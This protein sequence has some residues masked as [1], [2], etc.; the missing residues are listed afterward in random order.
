MILIGFVGCIILGGYSTATSLLGIVPYN[1]ASNFTLA[2]M[3]IFIM[4]GFLIAESG[5]GADLY[6]AAKTWLGRL[7][8]GLAIATIGACGFFAAVCGDSVTSA[9]TMSNVSFPEMKK[10]GYGDGTA[11]AAVCAGGA[12]GILIPPSVC[13]IIYGLIT[14]E[15]IGK[16]FIAGIIP[17]VLLVLMYMGVIVIK[18]HGKSGAIPSVGDEKSTFKEKLVSLKLVWP[19]L[20][21][22]VVMMCGMYMGFFTPNEAASVGVVVTLIVAVAG[23]RLPWKKF[24]S[25]LMQ[26][27]TYSA[28]IYLMLIG[29][30]VFLRFMALSRLPAWLSENVTLLYTVYEI[31]RVLILIII[32]I[33]YIIFGMFMDVFAT[34]LLTLGF[35]YPVIEILGYDLIWFG[36]IMT[37][38][39]EV[40]LISPPFGLNLFVVSKSC[41]VPMN[42]LYRGIMPF[43]GM[44]FIHITLMIVFPQLALFLPNLM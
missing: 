13:M 30:Y 42:K 41:N 16:L 29:C 27:V 33:F 1:T 35:V 14:E 7:R 4:M 6:V 40:G 18:S 11:A 26:T 37:R 24:K 38:M 28:M 43:V 39:M 22:F 19:I 9:V 3:P 32:L 10:H 44:D 20:V 2:C 21:V 36:I 17:G 25:A 34:I 12:I 31:P 8:G 5:L 15:S 23:R